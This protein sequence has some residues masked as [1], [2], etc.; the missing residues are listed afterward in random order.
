MR[1]RMEGLTLV[2]ALAVWAGACGGEQAQPEAEQP[3]EQPE[4]MPAEETPAPA[5]ALPEGV[6]E[7]MVAQG[8]EI[9]GGA[10]ICYTCHG[11]DGTGTPLAPNLTDATWIN[12]DGGYDAIV[13]LVKTGV[14]QPEEHQAP[15]PPMGGAQLDEDQVRAVAAY[16]Y[17]LAPR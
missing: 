12:I 5:V 17:T 4:A 7:E 11:P 13:E 1:R 14:A 16:V 6:T 8:K 3:A 15:M 9:F 2:F 10:G